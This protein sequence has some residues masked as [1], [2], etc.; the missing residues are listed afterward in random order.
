[1]G[2]RSRPRSVGLARLRAEGLEGRPDPGPL[3]RRHHRRHDRPELGAARPLAARRRHRRDRGVRARAAR[4]RSGARHVHRAAGPA[5]N[6]WRLPR[7]VGA[8]VRGAVDRCHDR[9]ERRLPHRPRRARQPRPHRVARGVRGR[10]SD[11]LLPRQPARG[12][13][14]ERC[15]SCREHP[16]ARP[17][18][19]RCRAPR[20][21]RVVG[22]SRRRCGHRGV[23]GPGG[24]GPVVRMGGV[25]VHVR[26]HLR[27]R[28]LP[29]VR[30]SGDATGRRR[31][32]VHGGPA[33]RH[34]D[35]GD[36]RSGAARRQG[37]GRA[38]RVL[39]V[40]GRVHRGRP[41]SRRCPTKAT[42]CR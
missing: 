19:A 12:P 9:A 7:A 34:R 30:G 15:V 37:G 13:R 38:H 18:P 41:R 28:L 26:A 17:I 11:A 27:Q 3:L 22:G 20:V 1:M 40:N 42:R 6:R 24:R 21:A 16:P 23:E 5:A 8:R 25:A 39:V 33:H 35:R 10:G 2:A 29:G 31:D 36:S 32:R 4:V 14:R